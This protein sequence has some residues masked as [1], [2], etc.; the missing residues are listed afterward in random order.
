MIFDL[1]KWYC[2]E[3]YYSLPNQ[4]ARIWVDGSER[5]ALHW[6]SSVPGYTFPPSISYMSFGWA[7]AHGIATP[8]E[9]WLDEIALDTK[10][11]GCN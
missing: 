9:V 10:K 7:E 6:L 11:I 8:W 1:K 4:E 2:L 5:T 3:L